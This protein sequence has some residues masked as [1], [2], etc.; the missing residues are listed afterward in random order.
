MN[1]I[2]STAAPPPLRHGE[3]LSRAEFERRYDAMPELKKAELI[4]GVVH[5]P[6]PV[7]WDRHAR[8]HAHLIAWL[9]TYEAATPGA[10]AGDNGSLRLGLDSMPQPDAALLIDPIC[11]GQA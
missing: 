7:C 5:I 11:G 6:S 4:D 10:Q 8:P 3:K 9:G 2:P 1:L